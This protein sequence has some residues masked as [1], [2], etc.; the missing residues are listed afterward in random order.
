PEEMRG[1]E[2][3]NATF[4]CSI[5]IARPSGQVLTYTG[6]CSGIILNEPEGTNGFGYDPLFYYPPFRKTFARLSVDEKN[7]VSHRGQA[8]GKLKD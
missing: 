8:M 3:R 4:V 1:K 7:R 6:R 2:N 5:V